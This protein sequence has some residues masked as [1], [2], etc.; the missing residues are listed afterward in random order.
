MSSDEPLTKN[1]I[2]S[3]CDLESPRLETFTPVVQLIGMEKKMTGRKPGHFVWRLVLSD[4]MF[5]CEGCLATNLYHLIDSGLLTKF[6]FMKLLCHNATLIGSTIVVVVQD[7]V[8][9]DNPGG[10]VCSP[11]RFE[12]SLDEPERQR[13]KSLPV[14]QVKNYFLSI[15]D[16][17]IPSVM[18]ECRLCHDCGSA[19]C[20]MMSMG[21]EVMAFVNAMDEADNLNLSYRQKRF[22]C[23]TGYSAYKHGYL[24]KHNRIKLPSCVEEG[25]KNHYSEANIFDFTGFRTKDEVSEPKR[26]KI[27]G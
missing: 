2:R 5:F 26:R 7:T 4:S 15:H 19:P 25:I 16:D 22:L 3:L 11:M 18:S 12:P 23:Y 13:Q 24:G 27:T 21:T 14:S 17:S 6:C 9:L 1:G 8:V 20:E 10:V